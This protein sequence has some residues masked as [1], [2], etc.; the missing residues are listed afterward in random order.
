MTMEFQC[1]SNVFDA[2]QR[3][4]FPLSSPSFPQL[5]LLFN[6]RSGGSYLSGPV[7]L[8]LFPD[9]LSTLVYPIRTGTKELDSPIRTTLT[10]GM[11]LISQSVTFLV[12]RVEH[13]PA[14]LDTDLVDLAKSSETLYFASE[15]PLTPDLSVA[16]LTV[17]PIVFATPFR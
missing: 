12:L 15:F 7:L 5:Q 3:K 10:T 14:T 1:L 17:L 9:S 8:R 16:F 6:L 2:F 13:Q 11:L 4:L